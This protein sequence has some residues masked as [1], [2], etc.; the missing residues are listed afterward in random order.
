MVRFQNVHLFQQFLQ[1]KKKKRKWKKGFSKFII[2]GWT[3][4]MKIKIK[5]RYVS[6]N[7]LKKLSGTKGNTGCFSFCQNREMKRFSITP[8]ISTLKAMVLIEIILNFLKI[9]KRIEKK[10]IHIK[11]LG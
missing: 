7:R 2:I 9:K 1:K 8:A 6:K 5:K 3:G 11:N 4:K 10:K